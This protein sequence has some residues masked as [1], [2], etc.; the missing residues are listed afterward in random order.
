[1]DYPNKAQEQ[2]ETGGEECD[3]VTFIRAPK[4][5]DFITA[6]DQGGASSF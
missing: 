4:L 5:K 3:H 6:T 2:I 1:M